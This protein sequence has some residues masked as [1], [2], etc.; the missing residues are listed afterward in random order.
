MSVDLTAYS[1]RAAAPIPLD[2]G[3]PV[4]PATGGRRIRIDRNGSRWMMRVM[5][6]AKKIEPDARLLMADLT[7]AMREGAII[8]VKQPDF[9]AGAPGSVAVRTATASGR[10]IPLKGLTPHY[11]IRK[12]QWLN[13]VVDGQHYLD[14]VREQVIADAAGEADVVIANLIREPLS[15]DDEI[16]LGSPVI[17]GTI[18][19]EFGGEW[20]ENR[21]AQF[22]FVIVEDA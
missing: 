10:T 11:A 1:F 3:G 4:T 18:E 6:P 16:I 9:D 22:G 19:G 21:L 8:R 7:T 14:L 15:V 5:L 20:D 2:F 17:E 12:G 13:Y